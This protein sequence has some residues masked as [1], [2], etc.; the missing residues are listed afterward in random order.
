[1][2]II[3]EKFP[4]PAEREVFV[5]LWDA[6]GD[7]VRN[8][9]FDLDFDRYEQIE[10]EGW[11]I[12]V[13]ARPGIGE[14]PVGYSCHWSFKSMHWRERVG[15]DD[16]WFVQHGWR[17]RG[18]GRRLKEIGLEALRAAGVVRTEDLIRVSGP[19]E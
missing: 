15:H 17:G 9:P 4:L 18:I 2:I 5:P 12:W 19:Q 6:H 11:L 10:R 14:E 7:E 16:L 1:M 3:Q 13:V 8:K